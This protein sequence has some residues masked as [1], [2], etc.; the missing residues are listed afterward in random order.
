MTFS[1]PT[2][3]SPLQTVIKERVLLT[4]PGSSK[5]TYHLSLDLQ[6]MP[7]EFK[8]GDS[9]G[10]LAQN[11]PLLVEEL[12]AAMNA[13]GDE[14]IQETRTQQILTVRE[15]LTARANLARTTS[16]FLKL[17][18]ACDKKSRFGHILQDKA[19]LTAT[20]ESHNPLDLLKKCKDLQL[21]LQDLCNQ[22]SPL[23]PRFYSIASSP[24]M[25]QDEVHLTVAV[26]T[27]MRGEEKRYGVASH[28]LCH[29]AEIG[30]T[31]IP[32][33]VQSAHAF[34]LPSEETAPIIMIGPGTGVAP[35]RAFLQERVALGHT[36]KNWLFFGERHSKTDY[37]YEEF[38]T[39]L[40][41][42]N[43]LRLDLAFSRDQAEK[44]Y[45]QHKL[46]ANSSDLWSWLQEGAYLYLCGDATRMAKD[47]ERTLHQIAE[48][49][50]KLA[51][52]Q[53][54]AFIKRLRQEKRFLLDVY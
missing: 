47:V 13:R 33:Y 15:F 14:M 44:I 42:Q 34:S 31:A 19:Q 45:V 43:K 11:D 46:L 17:L 27:F 8:P 36:G 51:S 4:K 3:T 35:F 50:G 5:E 38:W 6:G 12:L 41:Q 9:I 48:E 26:T 37:F 39:P 2:R 52:D 24:K 22:F 25:V 49:Q 40:V 28:F 21:P 29:L 53:A 16:S 1:K 20:L 23:L 30:K 54:K 7:L 10:V 32:I 18:D